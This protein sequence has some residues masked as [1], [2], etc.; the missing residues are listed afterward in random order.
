M[1]ATLCKS[2]LQQHG[3]GLFFFFSLLFAILRVHL[4]LGV[5]VSYS[6]C[7]ECRGA[8]DP[9]WC[10]LIPGD[11][12][13]CGLMQ[14]PSSQHEDMSCGSWWDCVSR[15]SVSSRCFQLEH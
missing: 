13:G 11:A 9:P 8:R 4:D 7:T 15:C 1:N 10:R 12:V 3:L 6:V 2:K 14:A 5:L